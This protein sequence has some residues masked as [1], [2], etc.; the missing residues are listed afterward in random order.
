MRVLITG[1]TGLIGREIV[2]ACHSQGIAINY[3]TT[4]K[5]KIEKTDNYRGFYWNIQLGE[6]D[7]ECFKHVD[8]IIHLAGASISKRWTP[9]Y[10]QEI[11]SSRVKGTKLLI[12]NLKGESHSIKQVI[13]ASAIGIYPDSLVN[14]YYEDFKETN[15][16]FLGK[17][18]QAWEKAVEDFASVNVKV[19]K[20]RTGLVLSNKG[21]AL[22]EMIKP[23]KYGFG[24]A[25]G[26]GKQWQSWIHIEDLTSIF[27]FLLK[28]EMAGVY[29]GVAPNPVSNKELTRTI[30][31]VIKRPLVLPNIPKFVLKALL[32][33]MHTLLFDSQRV[34]SK[35]LEN[36]GFVF[37]YHHLKPALLDLFG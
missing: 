14:Y 21:G 19:S 17:V 16:E 2:N 35:K 13:S 18:A 9:S 4:R 8:V 3:L 6:I 15:L 34:S 22:P 20:I 1:A 30:A 7:K 33:E 37:K 11:I 5:S 24:A 25:L 12:N 23:I 27:M 36:K 32:G 26:N 29:N 10:K 31:K 28:H